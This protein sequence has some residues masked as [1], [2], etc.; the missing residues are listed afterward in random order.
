MK[1][2]LVTHKSEPVVSSI[3]GCRDSSGTLCEKCCVRLW[4]LEAVRISGMWVV[5]LNY[6]CSLP[7]VSPTLFFFQYYFFL[8]SHGSGDFFSVACSLNQNLHHSIVITQAYK[9]IHL[10]HC[11]LFNLHSRATMI[12]LYTSLVCAKLSNCSQVWHPGPI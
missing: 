9:Y 6:K 10:I 3:H 7:D 2:S 11:T 5:M 4:K 1:S 8:L 12:Y